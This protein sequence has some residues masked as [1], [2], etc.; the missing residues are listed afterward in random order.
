MLTEA[1]SASI[2]TIIRLRHVVDYQKT[3]DFLFGLVD[4][5]LWS[6]TETFLGIVAGSLATMRPLLRYLPLRFNTVS[7]PLKHTR[8]TLSDQLHGIPLQSAGGSRHTHN[9]GFSLEHVEYMG[10]SFQ[11][12]SGAA[13]DL[14]IASGGLDG[15]AGE[16]GSQRCILRM[17]DMDIV[18]ETRYEVSSERGEKRNSSSH[19]SENGGTYSL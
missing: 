4:V 7:P 19:S 1:C 10:H 3:H 11:I 2:A 6:E 13:R 9:K 17:T 15:H 8:G 14:E 18:K 5:A 12:T 16:T